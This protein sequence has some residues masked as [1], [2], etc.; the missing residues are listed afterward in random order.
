MNLA[1]DDSDVALERFR[2]YL[3]ILAGMQLPRRFQSRLDPSDIVQQ[4]LLKAH[5]ARGQFQGHSESE[6][7]AWLRQIL[8]RTLANSLRDLGRRKRNVNLERSLERELGRSSRRLKDWLAAQEPSPS[9]YAERNEQVLQL[10]GALAQ[11]PPS[12]REALLLKHCQSW[13]L[14]E[15]AEHMDRTPAAIAS[16]LQRGLK[17][18]R[19]SLRDRE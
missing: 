14:A 18:L 11:L 8:A 19:Q 17:Q 16:L 3:R 12:Q 1:A 10:V 2:G 15:I 4:T 13:S 7:A 6:F 5:Q 9:Q